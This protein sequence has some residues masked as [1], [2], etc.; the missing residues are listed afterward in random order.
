MPSLSLLS[1]IWLVLTSLTRDEKS[2]ANLNEWIDLC[3]NNKKDKSILVLLGNKA[4]LKDAR[5]VSPE[6]IRLKIEESNLPYF[7]VSAKNG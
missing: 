2:F 1:L 7:E 6:R 3:Q 4:D 5:E